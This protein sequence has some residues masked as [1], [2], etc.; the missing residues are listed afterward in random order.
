MDMGTAMAM[1]RRV[2]I[3][4][5]YLICL[6]F[7]NNVG[8]AA[9]VTV[10]PRVEAGV[11]YTD[12][13]DLTAS[14]EQTSE[15]AS[16]I[17]GLDIQSTGND[18]NA[19]LSYSM[20]QL[21]YSNN[22]DKN[23]LFHDLKLTADKG[24]FDQNRFRGNIS[25][26]ISNIASDI[27]NNA[28]SDIVNGNTVESREAT[29]GFSYQT[30][31][32][33][34]VDL[35]A[36]IYG[37]VKDYKDNV[38]NNHSYKGNINFT[39]GQDIKRYFWTT[40]YTY[41]KTIGHSDTNDTESMQLDQEIGLQPI[42][43]LSPYLHLYYEDYSGQTASDSAD[44][45]SWGPGIK[46]YIDR[47]SYLSLGYEFSLD[48]DNSDHWRGSV[49]LQPSDRTNLQFEYTRRFY[50]D[51]YNLSLTHSNRR[52]TN[53]ISYTEE[54]TNYDRDL[55]IEGNRIEDLSI[56]KK[57]AWKSVLELRRTT[58]NLEIDADNQKAINTLSDDTDVDT[59][60]SELS[61]NHHLSRKT[62]F[63]PSFLYEYYT[64]QTAGDT[65]QKDY[66]RKL[67]LELKHDFTK[68]FNASLEFSYK[69]RSSSNVDRE[70]QENRVYLNVRKEL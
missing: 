62:S 25:A 47:Y 69:N 60:S 29:V 16:F 51:A 22:S 24:L 49:V 5:S 1:V 17:A 66:Y 32:A 9:D 15:I 6:A 52:W 18:G 11:T 12:N 61:L 33:G 4:R 63:K 19:S 70:Y 13:V 65:Y 14:N 59:Y 55:Y 41:Q 50:G 3:N 21:Y 26:S 30:N 35:N 58:F 67:S 28:S 57:L 23:G 48:D 27:T 45:S 20:E 38:G 40:K 43:S 64:F 42:H 34:M 7:F 31:P 8:F 68:D 10:K 54:V 46:Y 56:T 39:Q 2:R 37:S 36:S 53:T 44:S